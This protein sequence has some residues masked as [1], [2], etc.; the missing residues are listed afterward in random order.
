[1]KLATTTLLVLLSASGLAEVLAKEV[2]KQYAIT[3]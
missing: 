3:I 1:M 2:R